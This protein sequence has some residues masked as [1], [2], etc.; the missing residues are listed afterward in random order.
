MTF[1]H[2][3]QVVID[4]G[5]GIFIHVSLAMYKHI[6]IHMCVVC[7]NDLSKM[8]EDEQDHTQKQHKS[9]QYDKKEADRQEV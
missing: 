9:Y 8:D 6:S 3:L 7:N 5:H 4:L 1:K 2:T